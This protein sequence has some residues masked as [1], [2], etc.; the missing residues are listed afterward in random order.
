VAL[1]PRGRRAADQALASAAD[2]LILD[3][4]D[5]V[6]P[7]QRPAARARIAALLAATRTG[8]QLLVRVSAPGGEALAQDLAQTCAHALPAGIVLPKVSNAQEII[9]AAERLA[10]LEAAH[11]GAAA[12]VR[13]LALV[14]ETPAGLLALP[15]YPPLLAASAVS[16]APSPGFTWGRRT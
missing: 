14:T 5:S 4:E 16:R 3:L 2:A 8:P 6:A 7:A 13:L 10:V 12:R 9:A 11:G 15:Q 1:C